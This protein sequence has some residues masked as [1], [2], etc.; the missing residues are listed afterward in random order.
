M[1]TLL[2]VAVLAQATDAASIIDVVSKGGAMAIAGLVIWAF[3]T[4]RIVTAKQLDDRLQE[5]KNDHAETKARAATLE[6]RLETQNIAMRDQVV[7]ALRES[8]EAVRRA[9]LEPAVTD[10]GT[11]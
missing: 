3:A 4:D 5:V 9:R 7:P 1:A 10:P 2:A 11:S 8:A 6:A